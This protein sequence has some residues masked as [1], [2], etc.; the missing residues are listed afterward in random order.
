[1]HPN[2]QTGLKSFINLRESISSSCDFCLN[3][4]VHHKTSPPFRICLCVRRYVQVCMCVCKCTYVQE[5]EGARVQMCVHVH[6]HTYRQEDSLK[7][8][9]RAI[10]LAFHCCFC[11]FGCFCLDSLSLGVSHTPEVQCYFSEAVHPFYQTESLTGTCGLPIK[12]G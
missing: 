12:P 2:G 9:S 3:W 10:C 6:T 1:M 11:L 7:Y 4:I 5:G 8:A